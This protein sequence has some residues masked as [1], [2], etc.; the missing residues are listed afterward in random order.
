MTTWLNNWYS[1]LLSFLTSYMWFVQYDDGPLNRCI[2]LRVA[3]APV[4]PGTF[5]PPPRVTDPDM[6]HGTWV[7]H[8]P[9]CMPGSLTSGFLWSRWSGKRDRHSRRMR[10]PQCY[11]SG[12]RPMRT[13]RYDDF[14]KFIIDF[15]PTRRTEMSIYTV[16]IH[17]HAILFQLG[18]FYL[19]F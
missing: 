17:I 19:K 4:M 14:T 11:V 2:K 16:L 9:W 6:H 18:T 15:P 13:P 8:V 10:N 7:T 3:P 12:K 5:P 1:H